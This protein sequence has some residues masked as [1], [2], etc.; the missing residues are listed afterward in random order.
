M[1]L[2]ARRPVSRPDAFDRITREVVAGLEFYGDK[3][4]L[5][6]PKRFFA[7]PPALSD[8]TVRKVK[9]RRDSFYRIFFDSGYTLHQGEPGAERWRT[10]TANNR[11]YALLLRHPEP[12]P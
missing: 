5:E 1:G 6:K 7:R 9:G 2:K 4:W 3:G 10:Y 11:E 8:V 12:R